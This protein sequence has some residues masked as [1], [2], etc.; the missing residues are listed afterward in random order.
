MI[1]GG[2]S[3]VK[4]TSVPRVHKAEL[5]EVEMVAELVA[6]RAQERTEGCDLLAHR[7][8]HPHADQHR[9]GSVVAEKLC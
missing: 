9:L 2:C 5:L 8:P 7:R 1:Q 3:V 4:T 6:K